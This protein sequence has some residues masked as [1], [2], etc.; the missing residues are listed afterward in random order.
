MGGGSDGRGVV[1]VA[2]EP[3]CGVCC[4][5]LQQR[6][7]ERPTPPFVW[8]VA[9][10]LAMRQGCTHS[11]RR[12]VLLQHLTIKRHHHD[13]ITVALASAEAFLLAHDGGLVWRGEF[14]RHSY[15]V[16]RVSLQ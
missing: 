6:L 9:V 4:L 13:D 16:A 7:C 3:S 8:S 15:V 11:G 2:S 1:V 5:T 10:S 14:L 12:V